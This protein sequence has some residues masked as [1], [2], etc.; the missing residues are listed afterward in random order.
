[1]PSETHKLYLSHII[2]STLSHL[3]LAAFLDTIDVS[4]PAAKFGDYAT[5]VA[6]IIAKKTQQNPAEV[7]S[8]MVEMMK[9]LDT[10]K[11]FLDIQAAGGFINFKF[12]NSI[13]SD[14]I[15]Q[16]AQ[17]TQSLDTS[18]GNGKKV[19]FEYSSP[20]T[21]K[22]LHIGHIR[23]D[24]YGVACI[25]LLKAVG[26]NVISCELIN[27]RGI[28]IMKSM[29]MYQKFGQ[30]KTPQSENIKPDHFVGQYYAMFAQQA[31]E[32]EEKEKQL[33]AEA[34]ELLQ[35]W[36]AGDQNVRALWKTMNEWWYM[37]VK[38]TYQ[39]EGSN[40][41][42]VDYEN[43]IYDKGRDLVLEGV[44]KGVFVKEEDGSVSVDLTAD[45]LDKKY[46]LRKDGTTIYITQD[47]YL[48]YLRD[49]RHHPDLAIVTTAAE[50]SYHFAVL[51]K[52]FELLNFPWAKNFKHLPYEHVY[53]GHDK[54]SSRGGNTV[55]ADDLVGM[56]K[57]K[58]MSAMS[59]LEKSKQNSS[60]N[61]LVEQVAFGAI[62]YGYLKYEPNTRIFFDIDQT[63]SLEG[64][65]GPYIQ[66]AHARIRSI[67][68]KAGDL[69]FLRPSDLNAQEELSL[70]RHMLYYPEVVER[71]AAEYK[72]NLLCNYLYELAAF[73]N[74]VYHSSPVMNAE[75]VTLKHQRLT[76]LFAAA[77][78]LKSGLEILGIVA[79][80]E[81]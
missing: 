81:M 41:D 50:Q 20:N 11:K 22:A 42:E 26:Y 24:V 69:Q 4:V 6:M 80:D 10:E 33:L 14:N 74:A 3:K 9:S 55:S 59:G 7:A 39:R 78:T 37:G 64:N 76:L 45:K 35:K 18:K 2:A 65:T 79:P 34:Q 17:K 49:Q 31:L 58:V 70:I 61:E 13:L 19:L 12:S 8:K 30:E 25:N 40:F 60:N 23:N 48:W 72:P 54:M 66:Y 15:Y 1:M 63:I 44:S 68:K 73:C 21:N 36:E 51:K 75:N 28:H 71:A 27:D 32:S 46:L 53:L 38:E 47:L 52:L 57:E 56:I 16:L 62:K 5:N 77:N 67:I 29:L 43:Q